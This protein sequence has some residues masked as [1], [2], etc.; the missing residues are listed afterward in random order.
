MGDSEL[1]DQY[2]VDYQQ[3][4]NKIIGKHRFSNHLLSHEELLS[5]INVYLL[6]KKEDIINYRD[7]EK[8][9]IE[10]TETGFKKAAYAYA[11]NLI[12][13]EHIRQ[14]KHPYIQRR[15]N[16]IHQTE[17]G[18]VSTFE[19]LCD[20]LGVDATQLDFDSSSKS[21]YVFKL[22]TQYNTVL[23]D[24]EVKILKLLKKG[25]NQYVIAQELE[26][27]HQAISLTVIRLIEKI[28]NYIKFDYT[29]DE[30]PEK[31]RRG[32]AAIKSLFAGNPDAIKFTP[33]DNKE[34]ID[35]VKKNY[36]RYTLD[37]LQKEFKNG[38]FTKWQL[39]GSLN[40][41]KLSSYIR[42]KS[43]PRKASYSSYETNIVIKLVNKGKSIY[44]IAKVLK[45][46]PRQIAAK[47]ANLVQA[48]RISYYPSHPTGK[49]KSKNVKPSS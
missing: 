6:K 29:R 4:L 1:F 12:R 31:T 10:F 20:T 5:E 30:S 17:D 9:V 45:R 21:N 38:K 19:L 48:G 27:T 22:L 25:K 18:E 7:P 35:F 42:K 14:S 44:E 41:K 23:T 26:V 37:Q 2:L 13:W 34:L 43:P 49:D 11:C 39:L 16:S 8:N 28:K 46:K 36:K 47:C 24:H 33:E 32:R 15:N 3:D 40:F